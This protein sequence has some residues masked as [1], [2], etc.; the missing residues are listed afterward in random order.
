[1][2]SVKPTSLIFWIIW[3]L[4]IFVEGLT[5]YRIWQLDMLPMK[6]FLVLAAVFLFFA[7]L[8]GLLLFLRPG[9]GKMALRRW[10]ACILI[11]LIVA[12][13][14]IA[15]SAVNQ[16]YD[17]IK[18]VTTQKPAYATMA[19][20]VRAD[21]KA[22][23]VQDA[24]NYSF[25]AVRDYEIE[26]TEQVVEYISKELGKEIHVIQHDTVLTMID[27]L[28]RGDVDSII[29]NSAYAEI[30]IDMEV[31]SD[32]E[33]KV[34]ILCEIPVEEIPTPTLP[35]EP[36][37]D[38][39]EPVIE[40]NITNTPFI[41][42]ISGSDT[43]SQV[44]RTS[45]SDVN[46]LMVVNPVTKQILLLNTPR[47]YYVPNP[48]GKGALDK[49]THC[50]IYG[51]NCS[52]QALSDLYG[53]HVDYYAQINFTGFKKLIDSIGGVTVYADEDFKA[54]KYYFKK[55][56]NVLDGNMALSFARNRKNVTGG[57]NGRGKN[58]MKIITA[59]IQKL[60]SSTTLITNY[61]QIMESLQGMFVTSV[62]ADDI[63]LFVKMQLDDMAKWDVL[64]YAVT[65]KNGR[66]VTYSMP[67]QK[68]SVMYMNQ[69]LIDHGSS[70][71]KR[72]LLGERLTSD[73][74][75]TK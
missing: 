13:C 74:L 33:E 47:D 2:K 65:G 55:G 49:L 8:T 40:N 7:L 60:T 6:Y 20:Y 9:K 52:I 24:A 68:V 1:M 51:I 45:L 53:I 42:Y 26:K 71:V 39:T 56:E 75:K 30:L 48:S 57:D 22:K 21:D 34:R 35:T 23:S 64:S 4:Q 16:L 31:Y 58:Q 63:S 14:G 61:P 18:N 37:T 38:V 43:R 72:V 69:E 36:G 28:V 10:I 50:G 66:E 32:F 29:L 11:A 5:L 3:P 54:G 17:T 62:D 12:G 73:D 41:V 25:G 44:L 15:Y 70:L 59:I 19:L 67:G 27:A 46:I